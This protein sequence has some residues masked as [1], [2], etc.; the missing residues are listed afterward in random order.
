MP[1]HPTRSPRIVGMLALL[2][3]L[4]G[5]AA[6]L[7][8]RVLPA[9]ALQAMPPERRAV[10]E[11]TPA[12]LYVFYGLAT[13]GGALSALG[14]LLRRRWAAPAFLVALLA[15]LLQIVA[16]YATTPA[17]ALGGVA[18]L[19]FPVLLVGVAIAL[20]LFARRMAARDILR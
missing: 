8:Q 1:R 10:H 20:L 3:N 17:W 5:V 2:W 11:A 6:F 4:V 19:G 14:L 18:S 7:M 15:L 12:W 9:E 13:F 16:G